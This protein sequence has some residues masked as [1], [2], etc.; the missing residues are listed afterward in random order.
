MDRLC[1]SE[2]KENVTSELGII[3]KNDN[4]IIY[5]KTTS[6]II[7]NIKTTFVGW[8]FF[9]IGWT[10]GEKEKEKWRLSGVKET[11]ELITK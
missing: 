11:S 5:I 8:Q 6:D 9:L 7:R 2:G 4:K 3:K 10:V 1:W